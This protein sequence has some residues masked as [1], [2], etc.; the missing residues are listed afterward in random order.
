MGGHRAKDGTERLREDT[1]QRTD[2]TVVGGHRAEDRHNGYGWV[3]RVEGVIERLRED[4]YSRGCDRTATG[5]HRA[6]DRHN[7]YRRT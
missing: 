7:G 1:E 5:G 4:I 3:Y 2:I 6:E